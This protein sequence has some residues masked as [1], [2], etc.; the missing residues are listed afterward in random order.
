MTEGYRVV[1]VAGRS[2][3]AHST[4]SAAAI[5]NAHARFVSDIGIGAQLVVIATPDHAIAQT[6]SAIAATLEP[7]ALVMHLA[8][9]QTLDVFDAL[10]EARGDVRVGSLHPLQTLPSASEGLD[11]LA[12]SYAAIEGDPEV[13]RIARLIG[14][15]PLHVDPQQ[16][17][18]YHAAAVIASN[19]VVALLG[20]VE[21]LAQDAGIPFSAFRALVE[22]SVEN[23]F[24]LGPAQALTGPIARGD[25]KTVE[26]H[27]RALDP[28]ER[29]AY[30]SLAREA[31]RLVD[32]RSDG[33]DRLLNDLRR[34]E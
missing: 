27:L 11:R 3:D 34:F 29:D 9:S 1:G 33:I 16:R 26:A 10:K 7:N 18:R 14:L 13:E 22:A 8:G 5:C 4:L 19:H 30:R 20:Q 25:L 32:Q 12:G 23:A 15:I 31:A 2:V 24:E 28:G 21:R 6:A 17:T